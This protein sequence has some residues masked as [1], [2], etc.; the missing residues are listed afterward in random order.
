MVV[1]ILGTE[2]VLKYIE[3]S[4]LSKFTIHRLNGTQNICIFESLDTSENKDIINKFANW[5]DFMNNNIPYKIT[6]FDFAEVQTDVNGQTKI[7]KSKYKNGKMEATFILNSVQNFAPTKENQNTSNFDMASFRAEIINEI[8][9]KQDENLILNEIK[10]LKLKFEELEEEEEEEE[11]T[12]AGL[13]NGIDSNQIS[14]IMGLINM[15]KPAPVVINGIED[16]TT[17]QTS[18]TQNINNAIKILYKYD[19][20]LDTD[21]LKLANLAETKTDTFN[22][23]ISTLR[24]M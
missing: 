16:I 2:N 15:F 1:D 13:L 20:N 4:K 22:M 18:K 23:L 6:L 10:N 11:E 21:L 19:K 8:A 24:S 3:S 7:S 17:E 12:K 5:A 9:K 14:Q